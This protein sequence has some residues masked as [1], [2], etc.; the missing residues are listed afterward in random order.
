MRHNVEAAKNSEFAHVPVM[1]REVLDF[2]QESP[3]KGRGLLVDCT[4]GE[5]GHSSLLLDRCPDL[6]VLGIERD[7]EV[8][9]VAEK[10]L[11]QYGERM[12]TIP[13]NFSEI[14]EHVAGLPEKPS[15]FL[16]DFGISSFH[17]DRSGRGFSFAGEEP[18][19]MRLDGRGETAADVVNRYDQK[20]LADI[21]HELG[22]ERYSRR[23]ASAICRE[24]SRRVIGNAKELAGIVMGAIPGRREKGIHPATR[25]FQAL[26]IHVN[27]EL[28]AILK[29]LRE[30]WKHL[31]AG[32]R[33][34]A[35]AFHSL[36][37]RRVKTVFRELSKGCRCGGYPDNCRCD[38]PAIVKILTKKPLVPH[39]DEVQF[40]S[41]ARSAK[42][43]VCELI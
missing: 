41:R 3:M 36:E 43:R 33:I 30:A 9:A 10:R 22:E 32:G 26:R 12:R 38:G 27:D 35:I 34:I 7:P 29:S 39:H 16:Y 14:R 6:S 1:W 2:V 8:L 24:R 31:A 15:Y 40:N 25:V 28:G 4:L 5:G 21:F 13:G 18:L 11:E 17:F 37:D 19:D 42:M 23:I 20:A